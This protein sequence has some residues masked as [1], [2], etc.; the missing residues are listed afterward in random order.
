[1][2]EK[3]VRLAQTLE[4]IDAANADDPTQ[5]SWEG[6]DVAYA[7]LYGQRMSQCLAEFSPEAPEA[8]QIAARAQHICRWE[9][10]RKSYP[11][12]RKGYL[13]WRTRLKA[14]H[15]EKT[16]AIMADLG[17]AQELQERVAFLLQKRKLKQDPDTQTLE[18]VIC[19][20]FLQYYLVD[21]AADHTHEKVVSILQKTW[22]KMSPEGQTAALQ[23][24]LTSEAK[25]WVE[26]ALASA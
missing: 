15:A 6:K 10:P 14:F 18:D 26:A 22:R 25:E 5:V 21:F 9:I 13:Q 4:A 20:V 3:S 1:M 7:W 23:L 8:L 24:P 2:T 11:M 16:S 12:D 17:Y 19:L